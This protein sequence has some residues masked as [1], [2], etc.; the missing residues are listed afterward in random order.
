MNKVLSISQIIQLTPEC[1]KKKVVLAGTTHEEVE[2]ASEAYK[3]GIADFILIGNQTIIM[4]ALSSFGIRCGEIEIIH[5]EN[6]K[7]AAKLALQMVKEG[8]ADIPMK[9]LMHTRTFMKA[10]LSRE[11]GLNQNK[12]ISQITIFDGIRGELQFLTDCAINIR[13]NLKE[14]I[15]IIENAVEIAKHFGYINPLVALLGSVET[16]VEELPDSMDSA[17][18]TQMNRRGQIKDC[19]IDGPLSLDNAISE[20]AAMKKGIKSEVAGKATIL[21]AP[22]LLVAN[23]MGK[24]LTYYAKI[25]SA[26]VISGTTSPVIMTSRTDTIENKIN[27]IALACYISGLSK[28]E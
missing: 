4:E 3:L 19:V 2:I 5:E 24:A 27:A 18:L 23:T 25:K 16:V 10:V 15:G 9:G 7:T 26:S 11:Y 21:V 28:G 13:P 8:K 20:E 17:I 12:R 22:E 1:R 14:K 6:D